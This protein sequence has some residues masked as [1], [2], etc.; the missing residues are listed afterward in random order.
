[1]KKTYLLFLTVSL[2]VS[3][4]FADPPLNAQGYIDGESIRF[5]P[6]SG[7][8]VVTYYGDTGE[9]SQADRLITLIY[10]TPNKIKPGVRERFRATGGRD[11][12]YG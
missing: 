2:A 10:D 7:N 4:A 11:I 8:Y 3:S 1:M 6:Q 9:S 5:D 12:A